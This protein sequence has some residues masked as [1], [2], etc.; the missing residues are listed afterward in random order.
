MV[1]DT[2]NNMSELDFIEAKNRGFSSARDFFSYIDDV[3][4]LDSF[5]GNTN[6]VASINNYGGRSQFFNSLDSQFEILWSNDDLRL[7]VANTAGK[8]IPYYVYYDDHFPVFLTTA[9]ITDEMPPT[10]ER[11]LRSDRQLGRFW[12]SMEQMDKLRLQMSRKYSGLVIP[13]FTAKYTQHSGQESQRRADIS[14]TISYWGDDGKESYKE[15]RGK[16]GVGPTNIRFSRPGHFKFGVKS[17]GVFTHMDGPVGEIWELLESEKKRK[18]QVK[19]VINSGGTGQ[20]SSR[21]FEETKVSA[22]EPWAV[23]LNNEIG[24]RDLNEFKSRVEDEKWEFDLSEY[25]TNT[26][27]FEA[28]VVDKISYGRTEMIGSGGR[29]RIFPI[30]GNDIDPQ[31]RT[32]NL[33]QDHFDSDCSPEVV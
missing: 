3:S 29:I 2:Q 5:N 25:R 4:A 31:I 10:I 11:F 26:H 9:N 21:V 12:M 28:E 23:K 6:I 20:S 17:E 18:Q 30:D 13:F 19:S 1:E 33:V 8:T 27:S 15:M 16:Y 22:S 32:Y 14:R 24:D 7:M